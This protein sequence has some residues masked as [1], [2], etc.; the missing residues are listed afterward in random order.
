MKHLI[1]ALVLLLAIVGLTTANALTVVDRMEDFQ[2]QLDALPDT[3]AEAMAYDPAQ[4]DALYDA[5]CELRR[6]ISLSTHLCEVE[7]LDDAVS[8][9]RAYLQCGSFA[10]YYRAHARRGSRIRP[11]GGGKI[12]AGQYNLVRM[13]FDFSRH[14]LYNTIRKE[15][16]ADEADQQS[17]LLFCTSALRPLAA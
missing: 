14:V 5:W 17:C 16:G 11:A 2:A 4:V 1:A 8:D 10:N 6:F 9:L 7:R 3:E 12:F 15:A 13:P